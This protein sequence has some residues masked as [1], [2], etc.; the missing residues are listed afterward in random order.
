M[1]T[2]DKRKNFTLL[3]G[4]KKSVEVR[5]K[6]LRKHMKARRALVDNKDV[7]EDLMV[8]RLFS[9]LQAFRK[10]ESK[11]FFVYLSYSSEA[12]TDKLIAALQER[13]KKV[14]APCVMGEEMILIEIGDDFA[15][16]EKG[17]REPVGEAYTGEIDVAVMPLLAVEEQGN[18]LGYGGGYY[19]RYLQRN[20]NVF[21]VG[22]A[23]D[24]QVLD[25][26]PCEDTD[27]RID[28][29]VTDK[30]TIRTKE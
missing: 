11:N 20:P 17:I 12:R 28:V 26:V 30:R 10:S 18:R 1:D 16:S 3:C 23:Y 5:K 25:E 8:E 4:E 6:E 21:T 14:Y 27:R 2:M 19:D 13:G 9:A 22:F 29:V 24:L 7:K 15:L